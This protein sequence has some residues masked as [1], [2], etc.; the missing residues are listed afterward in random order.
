M[1]RAKYFSTA[2]SFTA[3]FDSGCRRYR[4]YRRYRGYSG[5]RLYRGCG[6]LGLWA[7]L[8]EDLG[9]EVRGEDGCYCFFEGGYF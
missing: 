7:F 6:L 2:L 3:I 8:G 1:L 4:C 5:Y 9:V